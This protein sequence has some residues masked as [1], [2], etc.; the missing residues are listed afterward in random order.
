MEGPVLRRAP[1]ILLRA[2]L[3]EK[4]NPRP[5]CFCDLRLWRFFSRRRRPAPSVPLALGG[6]GVRGEGARKTKAEARN[7]KQ[8]GTNSEIQSEPRFM[9]PSEASARPMPGPSPPKVEGSFGG[10]ARR[11]KSFLCNKL[12]RKFA[13]DRQMSGYKGG[14]WVSR[15]GRRAAASGARALTRARPWE[16]FRIESGQRLFNLLV[17]G[18]RV[19]NDHCIAW[20]HENQFTSFCGFGCQAPFFLPFFPFG[21]KMNVP[22]PFP[23]IAVHFPPVLRWMPGCNSAAS[24]PIHQGIGWWRT[25]DGK[26]RI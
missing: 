23:E 9:T 21:V 1:E 25:S 15:S 4:N 6:R 14:A 20:F 7:P 10:L 13:R 2:V 5:K 12:G 22:Y 11:R 8:S 17:R 26:M 18:F 19:Q 3:R 16:W 24:S